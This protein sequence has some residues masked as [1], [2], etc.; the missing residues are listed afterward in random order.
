MQVI[1]QSKTG[2]PPC[3]VTNGKPIKRWFKIWGSENFSGTM[4]FAYDVSELDG[5]LEQ[6]LM[7]CEYDTASHAWVVMGGTPHP[8]GHYVEFAGAF[9]MLSNWGIFDAEIA[10]PIQLAAFE[11][12][13]VSSGASVRLVWSTLTE[14]NNYG[15]YIQESSESSGPYQSL[16]IMF[17]PGHGTSL[18]SHSYSC[19]IPNVL[20]GRHYFRLRQVDLDGTEHFS[21]SQVVTVPTGTTGIDEA[22]TPK[23]FALSQ[24]YPNP[25]NP[26]TEMKFSVDRTARTT[27]RLYDLLGK[28]VATL[29]DDVAEAGR[30]Y[31]VRLNGTTLS[32]GTYF[33]QLESQGR[34]ELKKMV[35]LK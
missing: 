28:Q 10:L 34:T 4:T 3:E 11:A 27:L 14:T 31:G 6:N 20:P 12:T 13:V 35:L 25:F 5:T 22:V 21:I 15:F 30:S 7:M 29:F 26:E 18:N 17:V 8:Q 24:N 33:Y 1:V 32:S 19:S 9:P 16:P 23:V 2:L